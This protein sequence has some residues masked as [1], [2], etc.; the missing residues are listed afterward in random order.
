MR[1]VIT[2]TIICALALSLSL[3]AAPPAPG[4]SGVNAPI[5]SVHK[6]PDAK[7]LKALGYSPE[8]I[9]KTIGASGTKNVAVVFVNFTDSTFGATGLTSITHYTDATNGLL[10]QMK[11]YY[12]EASS[13][14][15]TG[16]TLN[17]TPFTNAGTGFTLSTI[18]SF[19]GGY[20]GDSNTELL[21]KEAITL[22]GVNKASG[23]DS[24]LVV[25]AGTGQESNNNHSDVWSLY[26]EPFSTTYNGFNSGETVPITESS[27]H[28]PFGVL[29][30]EFGHQLGLVD[31]YNINTGLSNIGGWDLMDYGAWSKTIVA[32]DTPPHF[33]SWN[34]I[35]LGWLT[36][37]T[38]TSSTALTFNPIASASANS[39]KV[40]ILGSST[41]YFLF[42][43][44]DNS[45]FDAALPGKGV[46]V[47]HIDDSQATASRI[48]SNTVNSSYPLGVYLVE[49]DKGGDAGSNK[50]DSTDPFNA[51]ADIFTSPQSDSYTNGVSKITLSDFVGSGTPAMTA[52]LFSI[53]AT[54]NLVARKAINFPN[55]VKNVSSTTI[56]VSFS[57]PFTSATLRIYTLAG[58]FLFEKIITSTELNSS[59]SGAAEEWIYDYNW[60]LK[61]DA[62]TAVASGIYLYNIT[63]TVN[64]QRESKTGKLAIIR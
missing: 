11:K 43:Y 5:D 12:L 59:A 23:Y 62:G 20:N 15:A 35:R 9:Q 16:L 24:L 55:P 7:S 32:G 17:F 30:H 1:R 48:A 19:Y 13:C 54:T 44:R 58:E 26:D 64:S 10:A 2:G 56:R 27:G 53:P 52:K 41:E 42:E 3:L 61:N 31:L 29:C 57:R 40:P 51:A 36:P 8:M 45:G 33:T 50:G 39:V 34:K 21:F 49:K 14:S 47:W 4:I 28:S 38:V 22:S 6:I 18:T 46:L 60:D 37:A 25:H 63:A